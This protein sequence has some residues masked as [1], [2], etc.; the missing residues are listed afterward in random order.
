MLLVVGL[1]GC[2][3]NPPSNTS[4]DSNNYDS[5]PS[6]NQDEQTQDDIDYQRFIGTWLRDD[7]YTETRYADGSKEIEGEYYGYWTVE[8]N[9]LV[10][11]NPT[12]DTFYWIYEFYADGNKVWITSGNPGAPTVHMEKIS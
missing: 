10:T 3:S 1:S 5:A 6:V 7:G 9:Q 8:N 12:G 4:N 11:T 2:T